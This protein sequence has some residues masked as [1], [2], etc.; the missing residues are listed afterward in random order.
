MHL[1]GGQELGEHI[2][3]ELDQLLGRLLAVVGRDGT[4]RCQFPSRAPLLYSRVRTAHFATPRRRQ[5]DGEK[6]KKKIRS[7]ARRGRK[8]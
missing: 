1:K 4:R 2:G 8:I 5:H 7:R 6:F 3:G